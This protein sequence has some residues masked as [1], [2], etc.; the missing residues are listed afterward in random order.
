VAQKGNPLI[1][2]NNLADLS[3]MIVTVMSVVKTQAKTAK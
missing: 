2:P 1:P 3:S